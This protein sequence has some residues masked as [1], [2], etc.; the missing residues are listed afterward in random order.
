MPAIKVACSGKKASGGIIAIWL[1]LR[2]SVVSAG[3]CNTPRPLPEDCCCARFSP[4]NCSRSAISNRQACSSSSPATANASRAQLAHQ[5]ITG[6][7]IV[8]TGAQP[9]EVFTLPHCLGQRPQAVVIERQATQAGKRTQERIRTVREPDTVQGL[10]APTCSNVT[11]K[12]GK[13]PIKPVKTS[14]ASVGAPRPQEHLR[15]VARQHSRSWSAA[16]RSTAPT[17]PWRAR[18]AGTSIQS[19]KSLDQ[20]RSAVAATGSAGLHFESRHPW[21]SHASIPSNGLRIPKLRIKALQPGSRG[22]RQ[23]TCARLQVQ[24]SSKQVRA[25]R[26]FIRK[27]L[28]SPPGASGREVRLRNTHGVAGY[29]VRCAY[30]RTAVNAWRAQPTTLQRGPRQQLIMPGQVPLRDVAIPL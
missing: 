17:Q 25:L 12:A 10:N 28:R 27:E 9:D 18:T 15:K 30:A 20:L 26:Y 4:C 6:A 24:R 5:H 23:I 8:R 3:A 13:S 21:A 22:L 16:R 2:L 14:A 19:F 29:A 1:R 7:Q 11:D